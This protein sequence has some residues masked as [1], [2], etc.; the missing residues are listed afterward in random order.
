MNLSVVASLE[1]KRQMHPSMKAFLELKTKIAKELGIPNGI[2]P[3]KVAGAINKD[4]K[5]KFP[6]A[7]VRAKEAF[8]IFK[9]D[10]E[11]YRK[12]L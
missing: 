8:N 11:K 1:L 9:K 10:P 6:D 5:D 12:M 4:L 3:A 2:A 7:I